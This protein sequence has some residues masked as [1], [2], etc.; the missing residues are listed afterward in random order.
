MKLRL[1]EDRD[2]VE[3]KEDCAFYRDGFCVLDDRECHKVSRNAMKR[4]DGFSQRDY[5]EIH[6]RRRERFEDLLLHAVSLS[7]SLTAVVISIITLVLN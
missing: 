6:W 3:K 7:L 5:I 1:V 2:V 4:Y